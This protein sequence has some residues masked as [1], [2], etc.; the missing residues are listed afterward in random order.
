MLKGCGLSLFLLAALAGGYMFAFDQVF[1]RPEGLIFGAISG[2]ITYFC[3]GALTNAWTAWSDASLISQAD[4]GLRLNDGSKIAV[5]GRIRAAGELMKAP[6]SGRECVICEY[7][8]SKPEIDT[9]DRNDENTASD[10]AGFLMTPC[11]I[12]T[13]WGDVRLLGFPMI[14]DVVADGFLTSNSILNAREFLES[15]DFEDRTGLK[16]VSILSV[17]SEVWS[18]DDGSVTKNMRLT[19]VP[20]D[21]VVP[22]GCE[23]DLMTIE[24]AAALD[25]EQGHDDEDED[26]DEGDFTEEDRV[27]G[28]LPK[29][30]E[31]RVEPGEQVVVFGI[32]N[33][34][35]RGLLPPKGSMSVNRLKRG[36]AAE[37]SGKLRSSV[38]SNLIGGLLVLAILHGV[39]AFAVINFTVPKEDPPV[40]NDVRMFPS[41]E[42]QL[43]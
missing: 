35:R 33:E 32:Y 12:E 2:L 5:A 24:Q 21:Q 8:I 34:A 42:W 14:D 25:A 10:F 3:I 4:F 31:K 11:K 38:L 43:A 17:F 37:I 40:D 23:T 18:D 19:H 27:F 41:I 26:E 7:D 22:F 13:S 39:I 20:I 28:P 9:S 29:L 30:V 1:P 15:T 16:V 36:T 6:F